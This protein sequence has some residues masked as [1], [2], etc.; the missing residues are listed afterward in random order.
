MH[1]SV[2]A[3]HHRD[4]MHVATTFN[5]GLNELISIP[6]EAVLLCL[7]VDLELV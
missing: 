4:C 2:G 6:N 5:I 3:L 7:A 1:S